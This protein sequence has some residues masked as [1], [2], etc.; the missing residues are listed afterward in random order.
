MHETTDFNHRQFNK[1]ETVLQA[2]YENTG[3]CRYWTKLHTLSELISD[4][5]MLNL[6]KEEC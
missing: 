1:I 3:S 2:I 5:V 4:K 6:I